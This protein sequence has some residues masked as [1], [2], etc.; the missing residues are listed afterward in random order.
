MDHPLLAGQDLHEGPDRDHASHRAAEHL[1][2]AHPAGET[3]DDALRFL[4]GGA[5]VAGDRHDAAIFD[6]DLGVGAL[7]D[8]LDRAASGADH[9]AD[10]LGVD[11]E[12]EQARCVGRKG[13]AGLVD[14]LKHLLEDVKSGRAGLVDRL[15]HGLD[16]QAGD[17]HVHLQG[18]DAL[19]GAGH[20][21]VHIAEE[22]L[23]ALDVGE[24]AHL[25][26]LLDQAH[27]GAAHRGL[28]GHTSIHQGQGAAAHRTHR[29]GTVGAEALRHHPQHV[30][31][32]LL[33]GQHRH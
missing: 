2:L 5:I 16:R 1:S 30:G 9:G 24:D 3:L 21:E 27:G 12:A 10:Q 19:F 14:G 8:A 26:T 4:G 29:G 11:P 20:L 15:G 22:V 32:A 28:E 25:L 33:A 23:D 18:G 6:V 17:L 13:V 7:G 31:E